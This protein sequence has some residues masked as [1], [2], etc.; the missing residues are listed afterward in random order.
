MEM[1]GT[2]LLRPAPADVIDSQLNQIF[3]NVVARE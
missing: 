2:V 3:H 1:E